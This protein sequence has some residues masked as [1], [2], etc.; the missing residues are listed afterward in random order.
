MD[1]DKSLYKNILANIPR[2]IFL[3]EEEREFFFDFKTEE[4]LKK[5][6]LLQAG[7]ISQY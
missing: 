6:Y 7:D 2:H 1:K 3:T 4:N 5:R